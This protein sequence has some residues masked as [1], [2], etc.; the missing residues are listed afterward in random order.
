[1]SSRACEGSHDDVPC[2]EPGDPS[3]VGLT[4]EGVPNFEQVA[5]EINSHETRRRSWTQRIFEEPGDS[6]NMGRFLDVSRSDLPPG[7]LS[8]HARLVAAHQIP[9]DLVPEARAGRRVHHA[10]GVDLD[11]AH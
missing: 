10:L 1:M 8:H 3:C 5:R 4:G 6:R 7:G 11:I 2:Y 9:V